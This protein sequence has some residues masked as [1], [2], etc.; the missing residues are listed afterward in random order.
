M[1]TLIQ[2]KLPGITMAYVR[3]LALFTASLLLLS[4]NAATGTFS[5]SFDVSSGG[6]LTVNAESSKID[7]RGGDNAHLTVQISRGDDS[8]QDIR[9][10]Y[11]IELTQSRNTV[12]VSIQRLHKFSFRQ[13][14]SLKVDIS[15]PAEFNVDLNS[16]GG[17]I[18]VEDVSGEIQTHT[19]GG[20]LHFINVA[21]T[22][23]GKTSGGSI[24]LTGKPQTADLK[25]SGGS[26]RVGKVQGE[27]SARTSGGSISIK[28]A[29]G[30]VIAKTS[31]GSIKI[32]EAHGAI[33]AKTSGGKIVAHLPSQLLADSELSTSGGS[34]TVYLG[35]SVAVNINA[36]TSGGRIHNDLPIIVRGD[37]SR[38]S[39]KGELN[40]GGPELKLRASGGSINLREI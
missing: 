3:C 14:R 19:S 32:G 8:E 11:D 25:T 17:S 9:D 34:V 4:V 1:K 29:G 18:K 40:G 2:R 12:K 33:K 7:V 38:V 10:D 16:S 31:G 35:A 24:E 39:L 27:I 30:T 23:Q 6:K 20:S 36:H 13:S 5:Q 28:G 37:T 21:G 26:I 15:L 22:V